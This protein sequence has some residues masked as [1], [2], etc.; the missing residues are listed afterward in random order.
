MSFLAKIEKKNRSV[1]LAINKEYFKWGK[2]LPQNAYKKVLLK[3]YLKRIGILAVKSLLRPN[4][5]PEAWKMLVHKQ[6]RKHFLSDALG[7]K[8]KTREFW[9]T[10]LG[11]NYFVPDEL[12][13]LL[14][15]DCIMKK[16]IRFPDV[17]QPAVSIIIP[18]YN[19]LPY[20]YN[21]LKSLERHLNIHCEIILIDDGSFD[22]TPKFL[23]T[24]VEGIRYIRNTDNLGF[25]L[26]C[27][28]AIEKAKAPLICLLNNDT[29]VKE[30]WLGS[31]VEVL[32]E[33]EDI[34]CVGSQ[35]IYPNGLLQEAGGLVFSDGSTLNFGNLELPQQTPY[36]KS[37]EVDYCSGAS[38]LFRKEDFEKIGGFDA[39]YVPAY[40]E[41]TDLCFEI[42]HRLGKKVCYIPES[43]VYHYESIT[44]GK[45]IK[46]GSVKVHMLYNK[47]KFKKKWHP[48]L[49]SAYCPK[50]EHI[51]AAMRLGMLKQKRKAIS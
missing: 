41:D 6:K 26:S 31:L 13:P 46:E 33:H 42:R 16:Q 22:E 48:Q 39:R 18:V 11:Y 27:N 3:L 50:G 36:N 37:R 40:Y 19:Q 49:S 29:Q 15:E 12:M 47:E 38:I 2:T 23:S 17:K 51:N 1:C 32:L 8:G 44:T 10:L 25:L 45:E 5:I 30:N 43:K 34:G 9:W 14:S 20:T 24:Q 7:Q 21:C 4:M 28:K 35:L